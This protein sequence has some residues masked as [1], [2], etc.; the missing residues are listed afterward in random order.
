MGILAQS[1]ERTL[2]LTAGFGYELQYVTNNSS[3][4]VV[5]TSQNMGG[6]GMQNGKCW[7]GLIM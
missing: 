5:S 7:F 3:P 2:Y 4:P 1:E 6:G